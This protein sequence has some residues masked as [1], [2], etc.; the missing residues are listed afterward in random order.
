MTVNISSNAEIDSVRL[1][2]QTA[3][4]SSPSSG[5][6][7]L[8][9]ISGSAHGGLFLKD[10]A[11]RQIGPFI[12]GTPATVAP[13]VPDTINPTTI[14][15][16]VLWYDLDQESGAES[17][18]IGT[19]SDFSASNNDATQST[20]ADKP[21]LRLNAANTRKGLQFDG[22]S[23]HLDITTNVDIATTHTVLIVCAPV[24][25]AQNYGVV[26]KY[27]QEAIYA[28]IAV[29]SNWGVARGDAGVHNGTIISRPQLIGTWG[30][31]NSDWYIINGKLRLKSSYVAAFAGASASAIGADPSNVQFFSGFIF[32][33]IVF[34]NQISS[35]DLLALTKWLH[36][37][38]G[39]PDYS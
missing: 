7:S 32:E 18:P 30:A 31:S 39:I 29:S 34:D 35:S 25:I 11:G 28:P 37:K 1:T 36:Y 6:G 5:Y 17:D 8:Y 15:G 23:D 4:P 22:V 3:H 26:F 24:N 16:C 12:T 9:V 38:W 20:A 10:S 19:L 33:I 27:K 2:Q 13:I 21:L 14:S